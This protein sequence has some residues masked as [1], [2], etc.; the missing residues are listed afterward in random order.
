MNNSQYNNNPTT[1]RYSLDDYF[2]TTNLGSIEQ[3]IGNNL[4]GINH[5]QIDGAVPIN[6]DVTGLTFFVKPQLN[7]RHNNIANIRTMYTLLSEQVTSI[8]RYTRLTL[9]PRLNYQIA[10]KLRPGAI[11][12]PGDIITGNARTDLNKIESPLND[13][14][15]AFIPVLSNNLS[16]ISGWPDLSLPTFTSNAGNYGEMYTMGD[17][18]LLNF[19]VYDIDATFRN[20]KGN[21][22]MYMFQIWEQYISLVHEGMLMPY[23]DM[24]VENEIDYN[25]RIYRLTLDTTRKIVTNIA[26]CG[27]AI[28]V[29]VPTGVV[30]DYSSD[31]PYSDQTKDITIRFKCMGAEYNDPILVY[32]FNETTVQFNPHMHDNVR[33]N[34]MT[35]IHPLFLVHFNNRGYPRINPSTYELEWWVSKD[36]YVTKLKSMYGTGLMSENQ[37]DA[38]APE[39][40]KL[41][42][43]AK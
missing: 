23:M 37:V 5:R 42:N 13:P 29:S 35:K 34:E 40:E 3:A 26:A 10:T 41:I 39:L 31:K 32:E 7:L 18:S 24:I 16:N 12:P 43:K 27:A 1:V 36:S 33:D 4:Y 28:P 14:L 19:G 20:T 6:K 22:I 2:K 9:D 15:Q 8:Q 11:I 25:T 38:Y 30:F 21:P 17:G